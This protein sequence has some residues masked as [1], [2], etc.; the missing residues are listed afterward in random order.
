M[1]LENEEY[2]CVLLPVLAL[3]CCRFQQMTGIPFS[4][5]LFFDDEK[6]NV[7]SVSNLG[8]NSA[9]CCSCCFRLSDLT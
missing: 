3:Y 9:V 1:A 7:L 8:E 6:R 4:Q 5:M 2:G